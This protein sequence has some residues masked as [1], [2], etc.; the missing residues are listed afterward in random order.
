MGISKGHGTGYRGADDGIAPATTMWHHVRGSSQPKAAFECGAVREDG[1][2]VVSESTIV[3]NVLACGLD[4]RDAKCGRGTFQE[5]AQGRE[6]GQVF[7]LAEETG[8]QQ[9]A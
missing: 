3:L 7:T 2:V 9:G 8:E 1:S 4:G 6:S 5:V